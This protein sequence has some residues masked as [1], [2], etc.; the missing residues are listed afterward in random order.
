MAK[1]GENIYHRK[2]GRWEGRYIIGRTPDGKPKYK[3]VYAASYGEVKNKLIVLK[4]FNLPRLRQPVLVYKNGKLSEWMDYWLDILE[5]PYI[6]ITTYQL[7]KRNIEKHLRPLL[8][9]ILL[10]DLEKGD[11][12]AA[13]NILQKNLSSTTLHAV[14]RQLKSILNAAVKNDLILKS[15]FNEEIRLP[16]FKQKKPA[17]LT[18]MQQSKLES[19]A[20]AYENF[21]Y[22]LCLYTGIRLG[23]LCALKYKDIDFKSCTLY[24]SHSVKRIKNK[25]HGDNI[26][27]LIVG[28][29]KTES[30]ERMIPLPFFIA[31]MLASRMEANCASKD[32]FIF[33]NS[34]G[35][36]A[37]PRT[38]QIR[39]ER[40]AE[41]LEI[42]D[43]H[44]HTLRHTFA[45]RCLE[46][47]MGYKALSEILG[48]S[49]SRITMEHYD[50]CTW[51]SKEKLRYQTQLRFFR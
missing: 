11:I 25:E 22:L 2:D 5:K 50:N 43:V 9:D 36:A 15:P 32:E 40:L 46:H 7:Y 27:E 3:S 20:T 12:Q 28:D 45:M 19:A 35:G 10:A 26:S 23:E 18:E 34:C 37:E 41:K 49:S 47:G 1:R 8:G 42:P 13:V 4:S 17:V 24:V 14:C 29:T 48:H 31:D 44:F 51:E 39:F 16:K 33:Q 38:L 21:E 6:K 30:S